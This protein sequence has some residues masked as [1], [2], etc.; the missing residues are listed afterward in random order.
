MVMVMVE[1]A[2]APTMWRG[3]GM[4][5]QQEQWHSTEHHAPRIPH[6]YPTTRPPTPCWRHPP[7]CGINVSRLSPQHLDLSPLTTE[8][9][10]VPAAPVAATRKDQV[11][12]DLTRQDTTSVAE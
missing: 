12:R 11:I 7:C 3:R 9:T 10:G 8:I 5:L 1:A 4:G 2:V 6:L